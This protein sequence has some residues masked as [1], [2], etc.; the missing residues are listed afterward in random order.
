MIKLIGKKL[1]IILTLFVIK[2]SIDKN[3]NFMDAIYSKII[4]KFRVR[5][6]YILLFRLLDINNSINYQS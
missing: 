6:V 5:L 4:T 1:T 2:L 3:N